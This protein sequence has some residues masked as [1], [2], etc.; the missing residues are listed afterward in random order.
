MLKEIEERVNWLNGFETKTFLKPVGL[1]RR[2]ATS[3]FHF[4][5]LY[6]TRHL[7]TI[8]I[9]SAPYFFGLNS[10]RR[11]SGISDRPWASEWK[12]CPGVNI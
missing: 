6:I 1:F 9:P 12:P 3:S 8:S 4:S 5:S 10:H 7:S 2:S 11:A